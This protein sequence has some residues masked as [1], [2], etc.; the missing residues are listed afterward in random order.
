VLKNGGEGSGRLGA[1][2]KDDHACWLAP[3]IR[4]TALAPKRAF[5]SSSNHGSGMISLY[6]GSHGGQRFRLPNGAVIH[7]EIRSPSAITGPGEGLAFSGIYYA[8][9]VGRLDNYAT[10]PLA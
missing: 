4:P 3:P 1:L 9:G 2:A 7:D 8:A 6:C 5:L 10:R